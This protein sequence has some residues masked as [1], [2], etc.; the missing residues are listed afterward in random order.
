M[1]SGLQPNYRWLKE[2]NGDI[3]NTEKARDFHRKAPASVCFGDINDPN[4]AQHKFARTLNDFG[5]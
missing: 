1:A 4:Y 3:L 2:K 5:K